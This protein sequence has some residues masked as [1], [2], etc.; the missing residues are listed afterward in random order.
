[1][2][3]SL[4]KGKIHNVPVTAA[5]LH[6]EGSV[7]VD[8]DWLDA[9]GILPHEQVHVYNITN[10]QRLITYAIEAPRGSQTLQLNGAAARR[11]AVG[12]RVIVAAYVYLT[13]DEATRWSPRIIR[14]VP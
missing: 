5:D 1:M 14:P 3:L 12:D 8:R 6:Y 2:W 9:A 11:A 7:A 10:G 13:P 4:L